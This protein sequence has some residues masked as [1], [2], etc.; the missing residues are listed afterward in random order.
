LVSRAFGASGMI[1]A[2][3]KDEK[4]IKSVKKV[5]TEWGGDFTIEFVPFEGWKPFFEE[6]IEKQNKIIHLTMYGENLPV[7]KQ[8]KEFINLRSSPEL[9]K[10]LLVVV[11]GKKVPSKV[12]HYANWN[13]AISN[14][15]HSEVGSLAIFL[16]HLIPNSLEISFP[17]SSRQILPSI[18]G[19]KS[20]SGTIK[21]NERS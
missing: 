16:S 3:E 13:I 12:F 2:G 6:W 20:Y 14:Q 11:G 15:P 4:I 17:N 1:I 19:K 9:L 18:E 10:N 21:A 5:V 7:F 8:N